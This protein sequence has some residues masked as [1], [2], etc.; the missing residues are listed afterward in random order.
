MNLRGRNKVSA[1]FSMSSMTDIVFLLLVFF[2]LTSPAITPEALDMILPRAKGKTT[3]VQK[4]S[5]SITKEGAYYVN[6]ERVSEYGIEKELKKVLSA[7]E[8]PTIILRAEEGVPIE[9]AVFVMDI[10]NRNRF[11]VVLAVRPD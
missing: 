9:D 11:K 1:E 5:V 6:K 10:A 3:N 4:A 7:Q 2:L 8:E